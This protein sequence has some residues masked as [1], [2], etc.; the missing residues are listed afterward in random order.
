MAHIDRSSIPCPSCGSAETLQVTMM[1]SG[2]QVS[3]TLCSACE[4]KGWERDGE[5]IPLDSVL[6]IVAT[7]AR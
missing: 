5:L 3:F 1:L 6:D 7:P 2:S 4:W